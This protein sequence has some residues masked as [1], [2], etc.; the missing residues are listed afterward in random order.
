MNPRTI[1]LLAFV[2]ITV[3]T[4]VAVLGAAV[5]WLPNADPR[6]VSWGIPAVLGEIAATVVIYLRTPAHTIRVNL[7]APPEVELVNSGTYTIFDNSGKQRKSGTVM[8]IFGPG[9]YQ[10]TLPEALGPTESVTLSFQEREGDTWEV[11]PFLPYV[12]TQDVVRSS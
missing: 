9:G 7:K 5:G 10:I 12:Q 1:A 11:R 6:L 3:L 2:G 8:P 4:A